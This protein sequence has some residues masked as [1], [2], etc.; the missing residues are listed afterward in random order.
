MGPFTWFETVLLT[1]LAVGVLAHVAALLA[2]GR[3]VRELTRQTTLLS[4]SARSEAFA[5]IRNQILVIDHLF[6]THP[7]LRPY[8][9]GGREPPPD[10]E[11]LAQRIAAAAETVL[12]VF[13]V[14]LLQRKLFVPVWPSSTWENYMAHLF[15][16]SPALCRFLEETQTWFPPELVFLMREARDD[17]ARRLAKDRD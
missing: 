6:V 8:F 17:G 4:D 1:V 3:R 14:V 5:A 16:R 15:A 12:D 10:D 7:E 9:Y 2:F 11:L 13:E